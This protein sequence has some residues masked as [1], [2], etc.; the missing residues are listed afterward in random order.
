[1]NQSHFF[2]FFCLDTLFIPCKTAIFILKYYDFDTTTP[3]SIVD[4][5]VY[6]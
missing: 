3:K 1:M 6:Y 2:L 4:N 5:A